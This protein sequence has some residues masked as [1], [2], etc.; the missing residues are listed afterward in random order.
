MKKMALFILFA[1][2]ISCWH[3]TAIAGPVFFKT[4][5]TVG[6]YQL[7]DG[8]KSLAGPNQNN[9]SGCCIASSNQELFVILNSPEYIQV[10]DLNGNYKRAI[11]LTG[12]DDTEGICMRD[13]VSNK[14]AIVEE[15]NGHIVIVTIATNTTTV[16]VSAGELLD[17]GLVN[18]FNDGLEGVT[19]DPSRNRFYANEEYDNMTIYSVSG[20]VGSVATEVMID[21]ETLFPSVCSD[22]SDLYYD[23]YLD[24]LF[25]LSDES[26]CVIECEINGT[27]IGVLPV[28][29]GQPEGITI[30]GDGNNM[31]IISEPNEYFRYSLAK[32]SASGIEGTTGTLNVAMFS[33]SASTVTVEFV[34]SSTNAVLGDDYTFTPT[35]CT[36]TFAPG[37]TSE[38]ISISFIEDGLVE[39]DELLI[40]TLTNA[41]NAELVRDTVFEYTITG[42]PVEMVVKSDR[43]TGSPPVGTNIFSY[44]SVTNCQ[45]QSFVST[46]TGMGYACT[47]W[48]GTACVPV[49]GI[50]TNTGLFTL[51]NHSSVTWLWEYRTMD[52]SFSNSV[53]PE[54]GGV[55]TN[56]G[57][58]TVQAPLATNLTVSLTSSDTTELAVASSVVIP[59]GAQS[60]YFNVTLKP[61]NRHDGDQ[62]AT[63]QA[64]AANYPVASTLVEVLDAGMDH[65]MLVSTGSVWR[66][67]DNGSNQ[68]N[69]WRSVS[70]NDSS[71]SNGVAEL[72]YGDGGESTVV[73]YGGIPSSKYVTTYFRRS[74]QGCTSWNIGQYRMGLLRDDGG[75]VY[76]NNTEM[77]RVNITT[78]TV[79]YTTFASSSVDDAVVWSTV[80]GSGLV[81]N[82]T[83]VVAVEMHQNSVSSDDLSFDIM[84][85]GVTYPRASYLTGQ[86]AG[87]FV[88]ETSYMNLDGP[89]QT[90]FSGCC[91]A[92]DTNEIYVT[93]SDPPAI[94][95]YDLNGA[96][97][98]NITLTGFTNVTGISVY[99]V[100]SRRFCIVE[101]ISNTIVVVPIAAGTTNVNKYVNSQIIQTGLG[102]SSPGE[103]LQ[104]VAYDGMNGWFYVVKGRNPMAVYRVVDLGS[105]IWVGELFDTE[106]ALSGLCTNLS[107]VVYDPYT[108][109]LFLLSGAD[110][111]VVE[112]DIIGRVKGT[113]PVDGGLPQGLAMSGDW[114]DLYT[115]GS[116]NESHVYGLQ[117]LSKEV[118]AGS[119]V[120]FE[121]VLSSPWSQTV[122][123]NYY[124][125]SDTA[126]S[127]VDYTPATGVLSFTAGTI[128]KT[129]TININTNSEGEG[130]EVVNVSLTNTVRAVLAG[131]TTYEIYVL[132]DKVAMQVNSDHGTCNPGPGLYTNNC[133]TMVTL[134][135]TNDFVLGGP[136]V[137]YEC[138]GWTGTGN[139]PSSGTGTNTG[140]ILH[141]RD[142]SI[143]WQ[144]ATNYYLDTGTNGNGQVNV[145]DNWYRAGTDVVITATAGDYYHFL[146]WSGNTGGCDVAG[147]QITVPMSEARSI[148]ANF[149][150]NLATNDVPEWWLEDYYPGTNDFD[151]A[152]MSDTD[153]DGMPAWEEYLAGTNPTNGLSVFKIDCLM[154]DVEG[155]V[156]RWLSVPG[157]MYSVY[158]S[159]NLTQAWPETAVTNDVMGDSS[160]TNAYIDD[161]LSDRGFYRIKVE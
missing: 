53:L 94:Q 106:T 136:G 25:V 152:A 34:V 13:S 29:G 84:M 33:A 151:A 138:L 1:A 76:L 91:L 21:A 124:V 100:P 44:N 83:N 89:A 95:V 5:S 157:K 81:T 122:T 28:L 51:T 97:K 75:L 111:L 110:H 125:W 114:R 132:A 98:T 118:R 141:R 127:N 23:Q 60:A 133:D 19:W 160:G 35:N 88:P 130:L 131:D 139:V 128:S 58:I 69:A 73:K 115:V 82:G 96:Y 45:M 78:G 31:Y 155:F 112:C 47:G 40:I 62:Y 79:T 56:W 48:T 50:G 108:A 90:N 147:N 66:Y 70:F 92:P 14:I 18:M 43:G 42:N 145:G 4:P 121:V 120:Q 20:T 59:T 74:F 12:V 85:D 104:G 135:V 24:H 150:G 15:G 143:T 63:I 10:Y 148:E 123:V 9:F 117:M 87:R 158:K 80:N 77:M 30:T 156:I 36:L 11:S 64:Q 159:T 105:S 113:V 137:G 140:S 52:I 2:M 134:S 129:F 142:S 109:H 146:E 101:G 93:V 22:L 49:S 71:W 17:L 37:S 32:P 67:L 103:G 46:G 86:V 54:N 149:V 61:D 144:W 8:P 55:L 3:I 72:G 119:N 107:D 99:D 26:N 27:I 116:G 102:V 126:I 161:G 41:S 6:R 39:G 153:E 57:L 154:P 38:T 7:A 16:D 65:M 68:S